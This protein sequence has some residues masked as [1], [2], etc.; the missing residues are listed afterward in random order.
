MD[1]VDGIGNVAQ[2]FAETSRRPVGRLTRSAEIDQTGKEDDDA[3]RVI[4]AVKPESISTPMRQGEQD[5][6][7]S[8]ANPECATNGDGAELA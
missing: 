7:R 2:K 8:T 5:N 4:E 1:D 3:D 6:N